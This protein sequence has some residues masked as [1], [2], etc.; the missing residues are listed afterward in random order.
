MLRRVLLAALVA[1]LI[2]L[3]AVALGQGDIYRDCLDGLIDLANPIGTTWH[4]LY[5]DYCYG[6][7]TLTSWEDNGDGVLS[8][9]DCIDMTDENTGM[10][11]WYHVEDV[12]V[13]IE[14][15]PADSFPTAPLQ[16]RYLDYIE[17]PA[18]G[19]PVTDPVGTDWHEIYPDFCSGPYRIVGWN[20]N[21]D[22]VLSFCDIIFFDDNPEF[23]WHIESV[24]TD[25][26]L[27]EVEG[28]SAT[29]ATTWGGIKS[30]F[31]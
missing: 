22:G 28:P 21:G 16:E 23:P 11:H 8:Y 10:V 27:T 12:T 1:T 30:L 20:D 17:L 26:I 5:P 3:P 15:T 6:P 31:R 24:A 19:D 29:D 18:L 4:E 7:W 13:T 2:S 25:I 9:C 14:I